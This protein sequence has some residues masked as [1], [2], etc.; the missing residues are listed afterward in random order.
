ML[1]RATL[2]DLVAEAFTYKNGDK[3]GETGVSLK[4][5]FAPRVGWAKVDVQPF[6]KDQAALICP[7]DRVTL[8][9]SSSTHRGAIG[10]IGLPIP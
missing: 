3:A 5:A 1:V 8:S 10:G 4:G 9:R 6:Y 7:A 2:S